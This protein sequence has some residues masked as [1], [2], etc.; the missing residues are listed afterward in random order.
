VL[1]AVVV[2]HVVEVEG[3]VHPV[4][5]EVAVTIHLA[6]TI[7]ETETMIVETVAT[8]LAALTTGQYA[9]SREKNFKLNILGIVTSK[10]NVMKSTKTA[11]MVMRGKVT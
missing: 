6:K 10:K 4:P 11:Q 3:G 5:A 7:E 1:Q 8:G 2:H 9:G